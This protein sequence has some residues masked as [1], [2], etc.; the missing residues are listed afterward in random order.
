MQLESYASTKVNGESTNI[1][2]KESNRIKIV[3]KSNMQTS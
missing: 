3:S 1:D 2:F